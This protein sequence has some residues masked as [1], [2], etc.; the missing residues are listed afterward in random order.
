VKGWRLDTIV[1]ATMAVWG[2]TTMAQT[3]FVNRLM[4]Q[5][6]ELSVNAGELALNSTFAV[7]TP[8]VSDARL[9]DAIARAVRRIEMTARLRHAGKG[10]IPT[11]KLIVKV[12]RAGDAVQSIDEDESYSVSV[13]PSGAE[14]DAATG[15]GAMHGLETLVQLVQPAGNGYVIPAVTIH[16]APRFRWR[17][18]MIDC[19]RHFEP[20]AVIERTL[21]GMAAVKLNVFH[22][23]LTEDQGFR[24]QSRIYPKLTADASDGLFYTQEDAKQIVAY[25]RARGI[26]VVPEFEMPGHSTAWLVA[27]PE[28]ASGTKPDSIRREFGISPYAIDPTREQTYIFIGR[29]LTEMTTIFPDAYVHIGGDETP[30]PDWKSNPRILAFMK[31]HQLKDNDA[32]QAYFNTRILKIVARLHKHMMGW[33]EVLTPGLPKDVVVQSWRGQASLIKGAKLG[34]PGVL[35]APYYLDAM[36]PASVHYLADP[37]PSSSDLTPDQRKLVLGGEV[38]MWSEHLYARTIDSRIWPRT[39]AIAERFWSPENVRDI[40]DMYRRLEPISI[41]LESLGLTHLQSGDAALRDLA[42]TERIDALR[43]FSS[44][45]EPVSFSE[46]AHAQH[47]DQLTPLDGFVDAVRPDPPSRYW[48]EASVKRYIADPQHDQADRTALSDWLTQLSNAVPIVQRQMQASPRLAEVS[49]RADQLLQLTDMG[50]AAL[51]YLANGQQATAGWKA[52]QVQ[53]LGDTK[54]PSALVRFTFLPSLNDLVQA[55][56]EGAVPGGE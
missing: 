38:C 7:E 52:K 39:A 34:Y 51:Q 24:I 33:D 49:M 56:S 5:P 4:P 36:H 48:F 2:A 18:L 20:V 9:N 43:T 12:D 22:W 28:L 15:V 31:A 23:H 55:V 3:Q 16:D 25:A 32:L 44:A 46:R 40:D 8:K 13:T 10:V 14:I 54:K 27:Y 26:R 19:G 30:A 6:A 47:T 45:L 37:L 21:D 1:A 29:F 50:Q 11:T 53:I 35:S 42:G 17:G 41:E